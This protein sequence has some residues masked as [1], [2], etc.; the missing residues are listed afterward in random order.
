MTLVEVCEPL[1]QYLCQLNYSARKGGRLD[2][3]IVRKEI[4]DLLAEI[5]QRASTDAS[6]AG[7]YD[8]K[9]ELAL[10]FFIDNFISTSSLPF[11]HEWSDNRIAY[12]R[13]PAVMT[14]D[15]D[16]FHYFDEALADRSEGA[17]QK[18]AVFYSCI[19]LGMTGEY[20][21]RPEI[22]R[23]KMLEASRRLGNLIDT[24]V[25]ARICPDADEHTNTDN[26]IPPPVKSPVVMTIALVGLIVCFFVAFGLLYRNSV[27]DL[28]KKYETIIKMSDEV[29]TAEKK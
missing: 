1:F 10:I 25:S 19:G 4:E 13:T 5:K 29:A 24:K 22:L 18:L 6:L 17:T 7:L 20:S 28:Q 2:Y 9:M 12:E 16:F 11:N 27:H 26:L 21:D 23:R 14:G 8:D 3:M 15:N